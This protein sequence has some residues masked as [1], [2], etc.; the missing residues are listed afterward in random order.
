MARK[1]GL[2]DEDDTIVV[3][4]LCTNDT[5]SQM[6]PFTTSKGS[7]RGSEVG[8]V[9]LR[10]ALLERMRAKHPATTLTLD[11]GDVLVGTPFFEFYQGEADLVALRELRYDAVAIGNHDFDACD[12]THE[13]RGAPGQPPSSS[14]GLGY[15]RRLAASHA[16][17]LHMLCANVSDAS[18][19]ERVF[20]SHTILERS[21]IRIGVAAVLG[22][23][24]WQSCLLT[25]RW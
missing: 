14:A 20:A 2:A 24:A 17:D 5:H 18:T 6:R 8:G 19:G 7:E 23:Q 15:L 10:A 9:A 11:A 13:H 1:R 25:I 22:P 21:G 12:R 16:P 4:L 3:Q